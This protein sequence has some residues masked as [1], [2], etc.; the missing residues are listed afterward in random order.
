MEYKEIKSWLVDPQMSPFKKSKKEKAIGYIISCK[1]SEKCELYAKGQCVMFENS[2]PYGKKERM[3]GYSMMARSYNSWINDFK[4]KHKETCGKELKKPTKMEY[5]MDLVYIPISHICLNESINFVDG[6][7]V[8][9]F[10]KPIINRVVFNE[11]FISKEIVNFKPVAIFGGEIKDYQEKEVPKFL[12][13]LKEL[14]PDLY[15]KV[16]KMNKEHKGFLKMSN[17]GRKAILRTI[18]PNVGELKDIYGCT[19]TWDGEYLHTNKCKASFM[20]IEGKDV[21]EFRLKPKN[22]VAV[23]IGNEDQVND[24]TIF[25]D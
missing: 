1:C 6:G 2:C 10:K 7:G 20:L 18:N 12:T 17:V 9:T 14:D 24:N 19:W 22:D 4:I 15:D 8:L 13:W 25:I 3:V 11:S 5:F 23:V 16:K 21:L